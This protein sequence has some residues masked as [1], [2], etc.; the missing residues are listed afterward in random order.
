MR[1]CL[2]PDQSCR[3]P[4]GFLPEPPALE[5]RNLDALRREPPRDRTTYNAAADYQCFHATRVPDPPH[6]AKGTSRSTRKLLRRC[7]AAQVQF[8]S[9]RPSAET[10]PGFMASSILAY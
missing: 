7:N 2:G 9:K 4:R 6:H 10:S 1:L 5:H 3:G 8:S